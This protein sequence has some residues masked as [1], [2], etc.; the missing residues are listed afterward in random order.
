MMRYKNKGVYNIMDENFKIIYKILKYLKAAMDYDEADIEA[1]S[2]QAL[3]VSE[4]RWT[5]LLEM[6]VKDGYIR[7]IDIKYGAQGDVMLSI[8]NVRITIKG[9]EYLEENSLMKR[10]ANIAKGIKDIIS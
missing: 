5:H 2:P 6:L 10:A 9:L 8:S 4:N 1:I 7:G 3:G